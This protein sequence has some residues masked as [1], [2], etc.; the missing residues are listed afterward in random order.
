[1]FECP[2]SKRGA[3]DLRVIRAAWPG[4]W[5]RWPTNPSVRLQM[6]SYAPRAT[7]D[8][9]NSVFCALG[10]V[11]HLDILACLEQRSHGGNMAGTNAKLGGLLSGWDRRSSR[12]GAAYWDKYAMLGRGVKTLFWMATQVARYFK[13]NLAAARSTLNLRFVAAERRFWPKRRR[14]LLLV[15]IFG[16]SVLNCH[17]VDDS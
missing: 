4:Y 6:L 10:G 12:T 15:Y 11:I 8:G 2:R 1:M 16:R 3:P 9:Q 5:S 7:D 14:R 13:G 17:G